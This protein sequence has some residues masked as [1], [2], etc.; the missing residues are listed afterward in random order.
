MY[1]RANL[2]IS[3]CQKRNFTQ[4]FI[5]C[6]SFSFFSHFQKCKMSIIFAQMSSCQNYTTKH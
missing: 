5:Y 6:Y 2:I 4:S 3:N 1:P